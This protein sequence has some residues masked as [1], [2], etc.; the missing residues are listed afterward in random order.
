M[1]N[2]ERERL[3][4]LAIANIGER[5]I[6]YPY[7]GLCGSCGYDLVIGEGKAAIEAGSIVT[8][9]RSCHTSYCE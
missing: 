6:C 8:G 9:C 7:T 2:E 1:N 4:R 5:W 3:L